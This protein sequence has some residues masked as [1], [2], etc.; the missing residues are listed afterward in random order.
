MLTALMSDEGV[1]DAVLEATAS[2]TRLWWEAARCGL[3]HPEIARA[4]H[5]VLDLGIDALDALDLPATLSAQ[6]LTELAHRRAAL[7]PARR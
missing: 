7:V 4:A 1:V 2:T 6:M 5:Q 3:A